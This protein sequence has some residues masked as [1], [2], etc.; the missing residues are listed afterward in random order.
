MQQ[1]LTK[2]QKLFHFICVPI[3]AFLVIVLFGFLLQI[4]FHQE[5]NQIMLVASASAIGY[6]IAHWIGLFYPPKPPSDRV[7]KKSLKEYFTK[8]IVHGSPFNKW[9]LLIYSLCIIVLL[10][11]IGGRVVGWI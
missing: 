1:K 4:L 10:L 8:Y 5:I 3:L 7:H 2:T 9:M 11:V 6:S